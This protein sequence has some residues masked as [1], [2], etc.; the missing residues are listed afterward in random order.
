MAGL[1]ITAEETVDP[2]G[3]AT[4]WAIHFASWILFKLTAEKY[5]GVSTTTEA[6]SLDVNGQFVYRPEVIRGQIHNLHANFNELGA[7]K[8]RLRHSP[9]NSVASVSIDGVIVPREEY[10]L[11]NN[12]YIVR[13]NKMPWILDKYREIVVTYSYGTPPPVAGKIAA[14]R[15]AN[16]FIWSET[17]SDR[18]SLP[19]RISS[20]SRQGVSYTVLDPQ[21]FLLNGKTGIYMVDLFLA[22]S[23]PS[24]AKKKPRVFSPD[25]PRGER[26]N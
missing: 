25:K 16:E 5:S 11:R 10:E 20:V 21:D 4:D 14:Q 19:E 1:W 2:Q 3:E 18:C 22:A 24:K 9:V 17:G 15:L 13:K 23:N 6:Y 8:I 26:I 12:A 7:S